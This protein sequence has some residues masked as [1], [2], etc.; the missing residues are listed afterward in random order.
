M[1]IWGVGCHQS[2]MTEFILHRAS[3]KIRGKS[4]PRPPLSCA[5]MRGIQYAA[6]Y[7]FHH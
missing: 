4:A 7:P 6:A 2:G 5:R 3:L 1:R